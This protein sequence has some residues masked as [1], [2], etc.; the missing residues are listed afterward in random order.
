MLSPGSGAELVPS[1]WPGLR[2]RSV[3]SGGVTGPI[4]RDWGGYSGYFADPDGFRW[5]VAHHP[6]DIAQVVLPS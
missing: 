6:G 1:L 5:E 4:R 2:R 3:R